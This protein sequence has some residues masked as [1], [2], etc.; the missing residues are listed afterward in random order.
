[1]ASDQSAGA[2]DQR[3]AEDLGAVMGCQARTMQGEHGD[4]DRTL[5]SITRAAVLTVPGTDW[6][7]VSLVSRRRVSSEASTDTRASEL[8]SLQTE[9][10]EGPCLD[11]LREHETVRVPDF[12]V[13]DRWPRFAAAAS[14]LGVHSLLSF[15]LFTDGDNLG[16]LNLYAEATGA[17]EDDAEVVGHVFAAHAAIALSAA[18]QERNLRAAIDRRDLIGQAKGILM[19]RHRL[20]AAQAFLVL[21]ETS[22]RTNRKLF[23]IAEEL[24]STGAMPQD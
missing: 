1:M 20:T 10:G 2:V 17:F 23:D 15:Q 16:A 5:R 18:R 21:V 14:R 24:T 7:S 12:G 4:V 22:S 8:D 3:A 13:E 11:A 6:A 19:E 9:V